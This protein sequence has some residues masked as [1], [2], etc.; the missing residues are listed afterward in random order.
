MARKLQLGEYRMSNYWPHKPRGA[1]DHHIKRLTRSSQST[2]RSKGIKPSQILK[3]VCRHNRSYKHI[4]YEA[5]LA[6]A[7]MRGKKGATA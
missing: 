6:K 4:N 2:G 5:V 3:W 7:G 1:K